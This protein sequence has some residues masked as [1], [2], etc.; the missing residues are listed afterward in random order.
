[1][2]RPVDIGGLTT[3]NALLLIQRRIPCHIESKN[4]TFRRLVGALNARLPELGLACV[5]NPRSE[6]NQKWTLGSLLIAALAGC[7]AG[8]RGLGDVVSRTEM[9]ARPIRHPLCISRRVPDTTLRDT[10]IKV[11][12]DQLHLC[13][14]RLVRR[15]H[16]R[17]ALKSEGLPCGI[18]TSSSWETSGCARWTTPP[19]FIKSA[20]GPP[21]ATSQIVG[22]DRAGGPV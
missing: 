20:A 15:A 22:R 5:D 17:N 19:T 8:C 4:R 21:R 3:K 1:M 2:A 7:A 9:L 6:Y 12:P 18:Y 11:E 13:L 14:H 16:R 10:L